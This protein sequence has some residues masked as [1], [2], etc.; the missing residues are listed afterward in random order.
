[1]LM[2]PWSEA[3]LVSGTPDRMLP[4][5]PGWM[6]TPTAA[7]LKRP[8]MKLI[9]VLT[10]SSGDSVSPSS[11]AAPL[12]VAVQYFGVTPLPM[13]STASR[14]GG[15]TG[16]LVLAI[17]S[18]PQTGKDSSHGSAITTPAPRRKRRRVNCSD[19]GFMGS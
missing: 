14:L 19:L 10:P 17:G 16:V 9:L 12:P 6:P 3:P 5:M 1:M 8:L 15:A 2:P 13:K 18:A 7:W 11:I 4:V